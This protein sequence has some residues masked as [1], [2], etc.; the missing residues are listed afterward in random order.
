MKHVFTYGSL[1]FADV[2][3]RVVA[4]DYASIGATLDA[5]ARFD[6]VDQ[7]YP[8]MVPRADASVAG[9]LH[10]DV[11]DA[12]VE[13]LDRFEGDDYRRTTVLVECA[14]GTQ[15]HADTYVYLHR[16]RLLPSRWEPDRFALQRFLET[17]CRDRLD[18]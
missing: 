15:R 3:S 4:A 2:W 17:Y 7:T 13:R 14:D 10:L 12:D 8:G 11:D 6:V 1:M 18:P 16:D 5:H 9:V